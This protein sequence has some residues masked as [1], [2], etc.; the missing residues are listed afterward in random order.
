MN[1]FSYKKPISSV[2]FLSLFSV[3]FSLAKPKAVPDWVLNHRTV[4]PPAE[5]LA[6]RGSGDSAEKARTD[7]TGALSR[8]FQT[9]VNANLS[10]TMTSITSEDSVDEQTVVVDEVNVNSQVSFFGLEYTE[11]Y[12]LASEKKWYCVVY[13]NRQDA[14]EQYRPQIEISKNTFSRLY[15]NLE[16]EQDSVARI[17]M[18]RK[19]WEAGKELLQ[20]LEYGRIISPKE[21]NAYEKEREEISSV[22]AIFEESRQNC[23]VYV[24]INSD[25][26]SLINQAVSSALREGGFLVCKKMEEANYIART[27]V[28]DNINGSD[29]LSIQPTVDL[30]VVSKSDRTVFSC[31]AAASEKSVG[32]ALETAQKKSYPKI[33]NK[34][35][36]TIKESIDGLLEF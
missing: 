23:T 10:T 28:D 16:K 29:P 18:C 2:I 13:M 9:N 35:R 21:E 22:P 25:Y 14:W 11:P 4:F 15:R 31:E 12:Y 34:I 20:K 7:A 26:N 19:A 27:A 32:Y 36:E 1:F 6:Q 17:A 33:A 3:C 24:E 30:K 5:F 8:Y